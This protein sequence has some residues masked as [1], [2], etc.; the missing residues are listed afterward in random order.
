MAEHAGLGK[1]FHL[2]EQTKLEK[3]LEKNQFLVQTI[4]SIGERLD[5][6]V[7]MLSVISSLTEIP[8]KDLSLVDAATEILGMLL[9]ELD[10]IEACSILIYDPAQ[11]LLKLLA[12]RGQADLLDELHRPSHKE[13]AFKPGEGVAGRV[14]ATDAPMFWD[15][16]TSAEQLLKQGADMF[17]PEALAC[18][19]LSLSSRPIGV[20]N[21]SFGIPTPFNQVMRRDLTLL[22]GVVA[23][24]IQMFTLKEEVNEK[25][26][27]FKSK[28]IELE[29]EVTNRIIA[30]EKLTASVE[31]KDLLLREVHH[32]VK[33]NLQIITSLLN[34][35]ER[36]LQ[37]DETR[38]AFTESRNRIKAM[39]LIHE[40][41]Y[42]SESFGEIDLEKYVQKLADSLLRAYGATGKNISLN[43][44][45]KNVQIVLDQAIPCGLL[46]N[47]LVSNSLKHA[48]PNGGPG[49]IT[50]NA[51]N[52][53]DG[54]IELIIRDDGVGMPEDLDWNQQTTMGL[55]L[56]VSLAEGQLQGKLEVNLDS[57]T[58]IKITFTKPK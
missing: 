55:P 46:I 19:P 24:V 39:A 54:S 36:N 6:S 8:I 14:F 51:V 48:Y 7:K 27:S 15:K 33:N 49:E 18:L 40:T 57:G 35:K 50:I 11:D 1:A 21:I 32:R 12:A 28:V 56:I 45:I 4:S 5:T 58:E 52:L 25:A 10:N 31:E 42:Q 2:T 20:L 37:S 38:A 16:N 29:R 13:L 41:L 34:L 53:R 30:E 26:A 23:N 47:E 3:A 9:R 43:I 17:T 44:D 22:S